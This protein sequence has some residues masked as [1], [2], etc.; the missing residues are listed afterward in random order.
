MKME[1]SGHK[2]DYGGPMPGRNDFVMD[3]D[4][5]ESPLAGMSHFM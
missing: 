4:D 1:Q 3:V 2:S 5:Y